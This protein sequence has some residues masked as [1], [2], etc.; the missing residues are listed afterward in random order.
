MQLCSFDGNL[1]H[2]AAAK[3]S[4]E[5]K[6]L[7]TAAQNLSMGGRPLGACFTRGLVMV[8]ALFVEHLLRASSMKRG[9]APRYASIK[10]LLTPI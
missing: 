9:S 7:V 1:Y 4:A 8:L 6:G 5:E 10:M 2:L 3:L